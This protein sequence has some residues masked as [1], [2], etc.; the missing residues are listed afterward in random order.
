MEGNGKEEEIRMKGYREEKLE[1]GRRRVEEIKNIKI[2][3]ERGERQGRGEVGVMEAGREKGGR[4]VGAG[5][6]RGVRVGRGGD[7]DEGKERG[8]RYKG[9]GKRGVGRK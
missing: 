9:S 1:K 7:K 8:S 6:E 3:E 5:M 4:E 2:G